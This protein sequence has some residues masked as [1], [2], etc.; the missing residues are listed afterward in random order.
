MVII[1]SLQS[2]NSLNFMAVVLFSGCQAFDDGYRDKM[3]IV[4][5]VNIKIGKV[6]QKDKFVGIVQRLISSF[7]F[8]FFHFNDL[9]RLLLHCRH[10]HKTLLGTIKMLQVEV[11]RRRI[12]FFNGLGIYRLLLNMLGNITDLLFLGNKFMVYDIK[13]YWM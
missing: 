3:C 13:L 8:F 7:F 6:D 10:L 2:V 9:L 4:K 11:V 1:T 12:S 5:G